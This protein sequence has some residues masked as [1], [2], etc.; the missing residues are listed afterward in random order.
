MDDKQKAI[1]EK[2]QEI[3]NLTCDLTSP[4]SPIGD[5]KVIKNQEAL[6]VKLEPPYDPVELHAARQ[7]VRDRINELQAEIAELEA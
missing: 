4:A 7:Q 2:Q 1:N 5:W 6:Q 3:A